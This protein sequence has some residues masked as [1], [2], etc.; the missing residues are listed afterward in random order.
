MNKPETGIEK[1]C[2]VISPLL[3]LAAMLLISNGFYGQYYYV[4][5]NLVFIGSLVAL[6]M[7]FLL[8]MAL[9]GRFRPEHKAEQLRRKIKLIRA[10]TNDESTIQYLQNKLNKLDL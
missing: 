7:L 6:V 4:Q 8:F 5:W 9:T 3:A 10:T 2:V 1:F